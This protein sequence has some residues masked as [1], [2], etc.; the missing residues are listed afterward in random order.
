MNGCLKIQRISF[1]MLTRFICNDNE[2]I[3]YEF[4]TEC[5]IVGTA[6]VSDMHSRI[7]T[8]DQAIRAVVDMIKIVIT[9]KDVPMTDPK[10]QN[11]R[12]IMTDQVEVTPT[13][14]EVTPITMITISAHGIKPTGKIYECRYS[15]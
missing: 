15:N 6:T 5:R 8:C 4:Q 14:A 1:P 9:V 10:D 2:I 7:I 3:L 11:D 12:N 13:E